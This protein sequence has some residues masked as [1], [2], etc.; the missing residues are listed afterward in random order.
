LPRNFC[1]TRF[2]TVFINLTVNLELLKKVWK[3]IKRVAIIVI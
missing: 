3:F 1:L 2:L